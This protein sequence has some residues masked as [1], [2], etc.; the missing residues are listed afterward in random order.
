MFDL[1][2]LFLSS[3]KVPVNIWKSLTNFES[4]LFQGLIFVHLEILERAFDLFASE[5]SAAAD[6]LNNFIDVTF[7]DTFCLFCCFFLFIR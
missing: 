4:E 2:S 3:I 7:L 6:L 5:S 1:L